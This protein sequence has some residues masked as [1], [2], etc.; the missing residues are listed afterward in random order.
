MAIQDIRSAMVIRERDIFMLTDP[1]GQIPLG[2]TSGYG[3]TTAILATFPE[4]DLTLGGNRLMVLLATAELGFS[5]EHVMTNYRMKDRLGNLLPH[6]SI[7]V[8]RTRVL[9]DVLE[10]TIQ[11]TNYNTFDVAIDLAVGVSAD[12]A[13]VFVV[14]GYE[15][16][17]HGQ[18]QPASW[19]RG[20]LRLRYKGADGRTRETMVAFS[21]KPDTTSD[22]PGGGSADFRL[23]LKPREHRIV[24]LVC[25]MDGRLDTPRGVWRASRSCRR[26]TTSGSAGQPASG[27]TMTSSTPSSVAPCRTSGCSGI[28]SDS[29]VAT[30]LPHALVRHAFRPRRP[31]S[32]CR[33]SGKAGPRPPVPGRARPYQGKKFD[34]WRD[35][36]PGKILHELRI[37]EMTRAGELPFSPYF[38]S[39]DSTPLFLLLAGE[40]FQWTADLEMM[41]YLE[42][43]LRAALH[44]LDT[45]GDV[46]GDGYVEYEKRSARGLVNQGWKDSG[47][48]MLHANGDLLKPPI[49]LVEVQGYVY[50]ALKKLAPVFEALGDA[51]TA[52]ILL[53]KAAALRER[54]LR[55]FWVNDAFFALALDGSKRP[56]ASLTTNAGHALWAGI[57]TPHQARR[58][59]QRLLGKDMFSGWGVRTLSVNSP[60]YNPQGYHVGTVWPHDNSIVAMGFKRYG[61]EAELN[62]LATALF[63]AARAFPYYRLPELFGGTARSAHYAPVPYPVACRPQAWAAGAFPL[64]TQ[65]ILGLCPDAPART[66]NIVRPE[67]PPWL[68]AVALHRMRVGEADV[69]LFFERRGA[70]VAVEIVDIR[71]DL[72]V[73]FK[74]A[75]PG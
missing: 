20:A 62:Q 34:P 27:R 11:V 25:T 53:Q 59:V 44:W 75:W 19:Q 26:N 60:R 42:A 46:D 58:V 66:L 68:Q 43:N 32:A 54:F 23:A 57:A 24:R 17:T 28:T 14:R 65:A 55:D 4:Y 33:P 9:E 51:G 12:F 2:N 45:Y 41:R 61:F 63:D 50:A 52:D 47:D 8:H 30:S 22:D 1:A 73:D 72:K 29:R 71:G 36:E 39:I 7:E 6:G 48:S 18:L 5:S 38:G 70:E 49:A 37:G 74:D 69:D 10:E 15:P 56:A 67:L 31:S 13:D 35:E 3:S 16:E 64:I 40:Y 21:P